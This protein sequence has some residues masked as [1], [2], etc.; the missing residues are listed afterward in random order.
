M[1]ISVPTEKGKTME[2]NKCASLDYERAYENVMRELEKAKCEAN[3]LRNE[4]RLKEEEMKW[5]CGFRSAV[6]L[7]FGKGGRNE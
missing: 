2:D 7:I 6:E 1:T 3:Y 5:L 4:L